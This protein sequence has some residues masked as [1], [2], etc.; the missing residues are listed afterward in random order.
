MPLRWKWVRASLREKGL[1]IMTTF[2]HPA[3][4]AGWQNLEADR[5]FGLRAT[6]EAQTSRP[7]DSPSYMISDRVGFFV[8]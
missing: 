8:H 4:V 5:T 3:A 7:L 2:C 6:H 1:S